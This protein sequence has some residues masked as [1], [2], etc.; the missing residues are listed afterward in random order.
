MYALL[1]TLAAVIWT[2]VLRGEVQARAQAEREAAVQEVFATDASFE[3]WREQSGAP[4]GIDRET[5]L[6]SQL[7]G[8]R[9]LE[10]P[11]VFIGMHLL[12]L[13]WT[14]A[15]VVAVLTAVWRGILGR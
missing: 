3:V 6:A 13:A 12:G 14:A 7:E 5:A 9:T 8:I 2:F 11:G 15:L 4:E 10:H 1:G